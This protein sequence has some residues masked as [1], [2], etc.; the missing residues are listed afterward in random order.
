[1]PAAVC[2][3]HICYLADYEHFRC[4]SQNLEH[5]ASLTTFA[6]IDFFALPWLKVTETLTKNKHIKSRKYESIIG[7]RQPS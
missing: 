7:K 2:S 1:M 3:R 6:I 5:P 4:R